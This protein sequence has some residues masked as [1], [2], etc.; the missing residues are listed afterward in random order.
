LEELSPDA[1]GD[2]CL[3]RLLTLQREARHTSLI[4]QRESLASIARSAVESALVG[5]Y[6]LHTTDD[7]WVARLYTSGHKYLHKSVQPWAAENATVDAIVSSLV[8]SLAEVPGMHDRAHLADR[9]DKLIRFN[10]DTVGRVLY[11]EFFVPLSNA[12]VHTGLMSL[13]RY[14]SG[15]SRR[16]RRRPLGVIPR[17]GLVR[18][19]DASAAYLA[20]AIAAKKDHPHAW[21]VWYGQDQL[22]RAN[23]PMVIMGL[24]FAVSNIPWMLGHTSTL[25]R[26]PVR[27]R[28]LVRSSAYRAANTDDRL[29]QVGRVM[30]DVGLP[31]E[32]V[33]VVQ[34]IM[35]AM[36]GD[37]ATKGEPE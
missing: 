11:D 1:I 18:T 35:R 20:A 14:Y 2:L 7:L 30:S 31:G 33:E 36:A 10:G 5:L 26:V 15:G 21:F 12:S 25:V 27:A 34:Q 24:R 6:S 3:R 13:G 19:T 9:V 17:R 37:I 23:R 22:A 32:L 29:A 28:Q 8:E 16:L 4:R